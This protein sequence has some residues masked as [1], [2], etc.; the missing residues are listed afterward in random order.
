MG[1]DFIQIYRFNLHSLDYHQNLVV[2]GGVGTGK[3]CTAQEL[4]TAFIQNKKPLFT[5]IIGPHKDSTSVFENFT[6][7]MHGYINDATCA[8]LK[9]MTLYNASLDGASNTNNTTSN[10]NNKINNLNKNTSNSNNNNKKNINADVNV[11]NKTNNAN[12]NANNSNKTST[13]NTSNVRIHANNTDKTSTG[14]DRRQILNK[15]VTI[16]N[17]N[18]ST[19]IPDTRNRVPM[20]EK[21][22]DFEKETETKNGLIIIEDHIHNSAHC[23]LINSLLEANNNKEI[24]ALIIVTL[25]YCIDE[26]RYTTF[27]YAFLQAENTSVGIYCLVKNGIGIGMTQELFT[28]FMSHCTVRYHRMIINTRACI[29]LDK[30]AIQI[31]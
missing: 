14:N 18:K 1:E 13:N 25:P 21:S 22:G 8:M 7:K 4:A 20:S 27:H 23:K 9:N 6:F 15:S 28:F 11:N 26:Y 12:M 10:A 3:T 31:L 16:D 29:Y 24:K 2:I 5:A 17:N 30:K 19:I